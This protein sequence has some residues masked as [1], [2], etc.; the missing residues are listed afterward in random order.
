VAH[1]LSYH[2]GLL[3]STRYILSASA[4]RSARFILSCHVYSVKK[5]SH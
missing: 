4:A 5:A 1:R 2:L 3:L